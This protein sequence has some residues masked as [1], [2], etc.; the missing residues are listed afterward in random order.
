M[1]NL[2]TIHIVTLEMK[3]QSLIQRT[4][5][6]DEFEAK[7]MYESTVD[8]VGDIR[9]VTLYSIDIQENINELVDELM[10]NRHS[11]VTPLQEVRSN[12]TAPESEDVTWG[13]LEFRPDGE[14]YIE[15][16]KASTSEYWPYRVESYADDMWRVF[17]VTTGTPIGIIRP[18]TQNEA[19]KATVNG[20]SQIR[21]F[22]NLKGAV[23]HIATEYNG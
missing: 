12:R 17:D 3:D 10:T 18:G 19:F 22:A 15:R 8:A 1:A 14:F 9:I 16:R 2:S 6:L 20:Y 13:E 5:F 7:D 4:W 23:I 11:H 21:P